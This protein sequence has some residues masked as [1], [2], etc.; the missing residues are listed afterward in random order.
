MPEADIISCVTMSRAPLVKGALLK[1]G[2]H[3]DLVGA[4]LPD[5]RE[6]DDDAIRRGTVFVDTRVGME[7]A[8]DL[9][10]PVA[11]AAIGWDAVQADYYDLVQGSHPGRRDPDEITVC[12]NV[13]GAHLD[14]FAA[15]ALT[16]R[17]DG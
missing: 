5:M 8:G 1:P 2:A 9:A 11:A 3:L 17:L 12:K 14:L 10:Q 16:A 13:G 4:Y 7:T 15:E 6:T